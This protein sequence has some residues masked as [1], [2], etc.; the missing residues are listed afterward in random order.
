MKS[1]LF[2]VFFF[3]F[4]TIQAQE[5]KVMTYN[6]RC[7]HCDDENSNNW[8]SRKELVLS[9]ITLEDPDII[10]FQEII[11]MQ[12]EYLSNNLPIYNYFGIGRE[13]DGKGEACYI[14][15]KKF[16][17]AIDSLNSG[18]KWYS[19]TP[20][21]PG[22]ADMGDI[23]KRIITFA[24]LKQL[25]N[26]KYFYYF[27][28]HLTYID[29][30]QKYHIAHLTNIINSRN[31]NDPFILSGDFN[32]DELS[33]AIHDLK[34]NVPA[35]MVDTYRKIHPNDTISTF[36]GFVGNNDGR[37]ID[38]IFIQDKSFNVVDAALINNYK[39]E[40]YPSDHFPITTVI[41]FGL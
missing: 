15:Y 26:N 8:D 35:P 6:I 28:T 30:I 20:N 13:A 16:V 29:S 12:L 40:K 19:S 10:G 23:Y 14:F 4:I 2:L 37:K 17:F 34:N 31:P 5:F 25:A 32:A 22:S 39:N 11:P 41:R 24:R 33:V 27:N 18:T 7:G 9:A 38:Y 36:N 21:V 1:L 3:L